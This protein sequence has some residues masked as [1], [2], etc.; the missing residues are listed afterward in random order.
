[1]LELLAASYHGERRAENPLWLKA[2]TERNLNATNAELATLQKLAEQE[3]DF[4]DLYLRLIELTSA[5]NDWP[6]EAKY[7][8]RLLQINPLISAPYRA[9]EESAAASGNK[10]LT[11]EASRHMLLPEAPDA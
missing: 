9:L 6:A 1:M 7:S 8:E 5:R 11:I 2:V 10:E 3:S 4:V